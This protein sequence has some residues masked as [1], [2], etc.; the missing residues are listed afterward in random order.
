MTISVASGFWAGV[1]C[2]IGLV[3][4][5]YAVFAVALGFKVAARVSEHE[6][7]RIAADQA[8][9]YNIVMAQLRRGA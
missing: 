2:G 1:L 3:A 6:A 7:A 4:L 5:V 8:E 9:D